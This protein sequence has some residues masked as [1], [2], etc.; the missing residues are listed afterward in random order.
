MKTFVILSA[1]FA[2]ASIVFFPMA[3]AVPPM[4]NDVQMVEPDPSLP[5]ELAGF[6]GK[7]EGSAGT[8]S[9]FLI[10]EKIDEEKATGH[11]WR[12][13]DPVGWR[14]FEANVAK[15]QGKFTLYTYTRVPGTEDRVRVDF[16]LKGEYLDTSTLRGAGPRYK[17]VP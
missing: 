16:A 15:E 7:W 5:K 8:Q 17:R 12:S 6:C 4:P 14:R 9:F 13:I 3:M 11:I 10:I 2:L 1:S